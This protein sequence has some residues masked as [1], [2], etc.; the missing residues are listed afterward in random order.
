VW[1]L[2]VACGIGMQMSKP[3]ERVS[4]EVVE[5]FANLPSESISRKMARELIERRA[6][7]KVIAKELANLIQIVAE[8]K[9]ILARLRAELK[10]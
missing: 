3:D 4:D 9:A 6:A 7:D 8:D 10:L 2:D 1:I 5:E